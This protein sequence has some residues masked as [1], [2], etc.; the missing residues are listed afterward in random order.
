MAEPHGAPLAV[1]QDMGVQV[2]RGRSRLWLVAALA[3][4][5]CGRQAP[6]SETAA[7]MTP[8]IT[9]RAPATEELGAGLTRLPTWG[10]TDDP[11]NV[12]FVHGHEGDDSGWPLVA[13]AL[14]HDVG[15]D[16]GRELPLMQADH[17]LSSRGAT[18][19]REISRELSSL[20]VSTSYYSHD[21]YMNES[22]GTRR[23]DCSGFVAYALKRVL[24]DAYERVPHPNTFKP[25]ANDWYSY[26]STRYTTPSTQETTRWRK[27]AK[28]P[29]LVRGDLVVWLQ[30]QNVSGDN[31]GHI[32]V[33]AG[34]PTRGRA[35]EWLVRI[36]D[37]TTAP[38]ANDTRGT[39]RTGIGSGT[40]GLQVDGS[41]RPI[42]YYWRGGLSYNA[43]TTP[44]A[45]GRIE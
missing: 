27:I 14:D 15:R 20:N 7:K 28:V 22:T 23:T 34:T 16:V 18:F 43:Y 6:A 40:V 5:G 19:Y 42:A 37:S 3:L 11:H 45:M 2:T 25:L 8:A 38:H 44:I 21:T 13:A 33:V 41:D 26:L 4:V 24:F 17:A 35:S 29:E 39:T 10:E 30:P 32:M 9:P 1:S 36:I 31:T 12:S